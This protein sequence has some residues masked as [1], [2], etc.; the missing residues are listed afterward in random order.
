[1]LLHPSELL[2]PQF[3]EPD[4]SVGLPALWVGVQEGAASL[5]HIVPI[6]A[7]VYLAPGHHVK[8]YW[9][10]QDNIHLVTTTT[11]TVVVMM[12]MM[13]MM[14]MMDILLLLRFCYFLNI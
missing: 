8:T 12:M 13:H 5:T 11:P 2:Q 7:L 3:P 10:L 9:T 4:V 14:G 1:M 6:L